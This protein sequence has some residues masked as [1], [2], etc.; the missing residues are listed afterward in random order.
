MGLTV[1]YAVLIFCLLIFVH[2]FGHFAAAKAVGVRVNKFALGMGPALLHFQGG[3]TEYSLRLLPIGGYCQME[4]EDDDSDDPRAFHTKAAWQKAIVVVAGATMNLLTCII[5]ITCMLAAM[6]GVGTTGIGS[7][8]PGSPAAIAGLQ[9]GDK[10]V[11][12][13]SKPVN[14]WKEITQIIVAD[15]SAAVHFTVKRDG[16]ILKLDSG[17]AQASD[18][19][20]IVGISSAL[21]KN[22]L[23]LLKSAAVSTVEMAGQMFSYLGQLVT[24]HGSM[25]DLVGPVG[26]VSL[27]NDEAKQGL[28]AIANLTAL[29]SLNLAIVNM[30]PLPALDG[31]RLLFLIIRKCTGKAITDETEGK[32][33]LVGMMLLFGFMLFMVVKDVNRFIL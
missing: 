3:E 20:K 27:I 23:L 7:V 18:G 10:I 28:L 11:D 31:G 8:S 22:P 33:H 5:I 4:G 19:H 2:E 1:I 15:Q 14:S 29:L 30:L 9:P 13:N 24:G 26:I 21:S 6:G 16:E 25:N 32:I 12:V 17:V